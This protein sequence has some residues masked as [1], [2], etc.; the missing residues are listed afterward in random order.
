MKQSHWLLCVA[1][2]RDCSRTENHATVTLDSKVA[3]RGMKTYSENRIEL[4]YLQNLKENDG[5]V[6][7]IFVIRAAL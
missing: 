7:S 1:K 2:N 6:E 5:K 4:R 3:Y